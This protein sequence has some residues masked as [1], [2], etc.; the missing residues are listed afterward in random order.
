M[1]GKEEWRPVKGYEGR[2]EISSYGRIRSL[3]RDVIQIFN[4]IPHTR[5]LKG[6][7][8]KPTSNG[9]GYL[10]VR[11][12]IPEQ[13]QKT[14]KILVI[15]REVAK[16]FI[17]NPNNYPVVNH[18]DGNKSNNISSN[19]EWCTYQYNTQHAY[20]NGH[21]PINPRK[22]KIRCI[23]NGMIF[24]SETSAANWAGGNQ[25]NVST[26]IRKGWALKG[27]HFEYVK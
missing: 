19:L 18:I 1:S 4:G 17:P 5:H 2:Y 27:F 25:S 12:I 16:T 20:N 3:D 21:A 13:S 23:E 24:E 22:I 7:L 26:A 10:S 6:K 15:H 9:N 14:V 8:L 11:V